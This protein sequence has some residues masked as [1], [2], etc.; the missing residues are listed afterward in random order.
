MRGSR[1]CRPRS[2]RTQRDG[3]QGRRSIDNLNRNAKH[4]PRA[5]LGTDVARFR[6]IGLELAPQPQDLRV[7]RS[8]VDV[9]A[10]QAGQSRSWSR[11]STRLGAPRKT[12]RR[13]NS[14]LL[15]G[16]ARPSRFLTIRA[17]RRAFVPAGVRLCGR[18]A[19]RTT[20]IEQ[21]ASR[22]THGSSNGLPGPESAS[23]PASLAHEW[24]QETPPNR[25][26]R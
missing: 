24:P 12:T 18:D 10:V 9:I 6:R 19:V 20:K 17:D 15:S 5:A 23:T 3:G 22:L 26:P 13:L 4:V 7:D 8:V 25:Q 21:Q 2:Q 16:T 1:Q 11:V 14:P